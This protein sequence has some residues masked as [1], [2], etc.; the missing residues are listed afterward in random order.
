MIPSTHIVHVSVWMSVWYHGIHQKIEIMLIK[1][2]E[3]EK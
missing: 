1:K 2:K 3:K